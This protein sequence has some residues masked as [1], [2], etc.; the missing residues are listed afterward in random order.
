MQRET[1][2]Y[3]HKLDGHV[4][5]KKVLTS[6]CFAGSGEEGVM[7]DAKRDKCVHT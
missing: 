4:N 7:E 1:N 6:C 3:I 2:V 5:K